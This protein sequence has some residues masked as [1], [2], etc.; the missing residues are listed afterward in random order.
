MQIVNTIQDVY[1]AIEEVILL[2]NNDRHKEFSVKLD[3]RMHQVSWTSSSELLEE[4]KDIIKCALLVVVDMDKELVKQMECIV[5][6]IELE[7]KNT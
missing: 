4:L 2:L 5:K 1:P 7:D 3:H 6:I